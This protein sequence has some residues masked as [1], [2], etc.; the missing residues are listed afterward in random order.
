M[1]N[2]PSPPSSP[3]GRATTTLADFID[4]NQRI[5][6][7]LGVFTALTVFAGNLR[8][9]EFGQLLSS[10]FLTLTLL[11]WLELWGRFPAQG[12]GWRLDWFENILAFTVLILVGYWVAIVHAH[13]HDLLTILIWGFT[14]A[15]VSK[16]VRH[17]GLFNRVFR[18]IP[19]GRR[20]LRYSVGIVLQLLVLALALGVAGLLGP[21]LDRLVDRLQTGATAPSAGAVTPP[22]C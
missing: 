11:I 15:G 13:I 19:D 21:P 17:Y 2:S 18:T 12:T 3:K 1:E 8:P 7:V 22:P 6:T 4:E 10:L 5:I 16:L 14:L 20:G 9:E